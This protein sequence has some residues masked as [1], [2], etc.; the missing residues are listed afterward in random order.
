MKKDTK[1]QPTMTILK[2]DPKET[3]ELITRT[4][5]D[6]SP[7]IIITTNGESFGTLGKYRITEPYHTIEQCKKELEKITWNRIIQVCL[8][9]N[10]TY[11]EHIENNI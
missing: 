2:A 11:K 8:L 6:N 10:E 1:E 3:N 9:L 4:E 7:F 5:V